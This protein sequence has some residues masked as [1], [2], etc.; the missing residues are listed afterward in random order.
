[1]HPF[2][3]FAAVLS[4]CA[5]APTSVPNGQL[6]SANSPS[7]PEPIRGRLGASILGPQNIPIELQNADALAPPTTDNGQI[8]NMKWSFSQ[9]HNRLGDGGW[10]RQQTMD[11]MPV[12]TELAGVN[13]RL[14]PGAIRELH[15]HSTAEW[16]YMLK[17]DVRISTMTPDGEIYVGDVTEGD[18]WYFPPGNPHSIQAKNTT[19]GGAEFLLVFDSGAFS[20][21]A[22]FLLT[23]WLAHVPKE[24]LALNFG[25]SISAFDGIP[26]KPPYIFQSSPPPEDVNADMVIP[27][28]TPNPFTFA[29]SKMP[30]TKKPGGSIK[31]IDSRQFKV[32]QAISAVEVTVEPGAMRELHWHPTEPEWTFFISGEA[33]MTIF[34]ASSKARTYDFYAGD[35]G[36]V[37]PSFGHYIMNTGNTTLRFLEIFKSSLAQ[38]ISLTQWLA[39]TPAELVKAHLGFSD[40]VIASLSRVKQV[41]V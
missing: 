14:E 21:D 32:S 4:L 30:A 5:A 17:G 36:Y 12:A 15:W 9:S 13:M 3:P 38:D 6:W 33:R 28:N 10:A 7:T 20:E 29:L 22:T 26:A 35:I 39:L 27:N 16:A 1:M 37:P 11:S 23:D 31:V 2:L 41:V 18:I 40:E 19:E 25:Q 8:P 34:A 24:V